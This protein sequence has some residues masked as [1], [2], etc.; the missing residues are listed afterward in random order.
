MFCI[1]FS[2]SLKLSKTIK[3][4]FFKIKVVVFT[5]VEIYNEDT[6]DLRS[7]NHHGS[8]RKVFDKNITEVKN[9]NNG[10]VLTKNNFGDVAKFVGKYNYIHV[11]VSHLIIKLKFVI[12]HI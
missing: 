11:S 12:V 8:E 5:I 3:Y 10:F 4:I 9:K 6:A 2:L 7:I 1:T